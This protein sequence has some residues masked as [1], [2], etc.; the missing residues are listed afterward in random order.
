MRLPHSSS[1]CCYSS[2]DF[3][4]FS[5]VT[6]TRKVYI[7]IKN[8]PADYLPIAYIRLLLKGVLSL[9]HTYFKARSSYDYSAEKRS[10]ITRSDS[11]GSKASRMSFT[12]TSQ[13][14]IH[15]PKPQTTVRNVSVRELL[16]DFVLQHRNGASLFMGVVT[17]KATK[18]NGSTEGFKSRW[19]PLLVSSNTSGGATGD[20][21]SGGEQL[22]NANWFETDSNTVWPFN[23][24]PS[25]EDLID[26]YV[27]ASI[28]EPKQYD[29]EYKASRGDNIKIQRANRQMQVRRVSSQIYVTL[30]QDSPLVI[31]AVQECEVF[32]R[33]KRAD[34]A[35]VLGA[36][37]DAARLASP[38]F[39]VRQEVVRAIYKTETTSG[40]ASIT[41]STTFWNENKWNETQQKNVLHALGLRQKNSPVMPPLKSPYIKHRT[42]QRRRRKSK[43]SLNHGHFDFFLGQELT[44]CL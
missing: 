29:V 21:Y 24:W 7:Q 8:S 32:N 22:V 44:A 15:V 13:S 31:L 41:S 30:V 5:C 38:N 34:S 2:T 17:R 42:F 25:I 23:I 37:E 3:S 35:G 26:E 16:K 19:L 9:M 11:G 14:P 40:E 39:L 28:P 20:R 43:T 10:S 27:L 33:R 36:L 1:S 12:L 4:Y 18:T 6:L